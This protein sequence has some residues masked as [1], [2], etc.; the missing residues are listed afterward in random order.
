M[1]A[2]LQ[3]FQ[4][5][6]INHDIMLHPAWRGDVRGLHAEKILKKHQTP[7]LYIL[8]AGEKT[9]ENE[10]DYYVSFLLPDLTTKHVPFI[11]TVLSEGWYYD[12]TGSGGPYN[13]STIDDVLYLIM[14]CNKEECKPLQK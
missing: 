10:T 6:T 5:S 12:N 11:I 8:R 13:N 3:T 7:Y 4:L 9:T 1:S 14:H 2:L